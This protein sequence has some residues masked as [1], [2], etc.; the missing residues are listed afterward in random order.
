ME[1]PKKVIGEEPDE[2]EGSE[3]DH[4]ASKRGGRKDA[5]VE[6]KDGEFDGGDGCAVELCRNKDGLLCCS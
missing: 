1:S 6:E 4:P 5:A 2:D 3:E